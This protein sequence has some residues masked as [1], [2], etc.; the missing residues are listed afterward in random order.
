LQ[1]LQKEIETE[2]EK[3]EDLYKKFQCYCTGNNENLNKAGEEAAAQIETLSAKVKQETAEKKQVEAELKQHKKDKADA[4]ADLDQATKIRQKEHAEYVANAGDTKQNIESTIS[5]IDALEKGGSAFLQTPMVGKLQALV[6]TGAFLD[7][8]DR[9]QVDA[10][11]QQS[12]DYVPQGGQ[13]V[14]I[15]KNMKD[16]MDKSLGGIVSE[17]ESDA[18][19]FA[20]LKAAKTKEIK[21]ATE[22][23][24]AKTQRKGELAVS[25]VQNENAAEDAT[26]ELSDAQKFLANLK[27][28]CADKAADYEERTKTRHQE[29]VAIG[30]AISV[31][32]DDDALDV[33]KKS[34]PSPEPAPQ[35][36][37]ASFL[38][39]GSKKANVSQKVK[40]LVSNL[41]ARKQSSAI[42]LLAHTVSIKLATGV[43]FTKVL[44]MVDDMV[45]LLIQEGKDDEKHKNFCD[46]EFDSSDDENKAV[47]RKLASLAS[48]ISEINDEIAAL[49]D[50]IAVH[51]KEI[52]DLD[53]S[54][55]EA[56][57]QREEEHKEYTTKVQLNEAAI[58]LIH[59]AK[60][61]MNKFYNPSQYV[62]PK[63]RELTAEDRAIIAAGGEV[64]RS[65]P[66]QVIAGTQ[67]TVFVQLHTQENDKDAPAPPPETY[68]EYKK[69][70]EKSNGV[71]ALMDKLAR[72]LE[73]E[74]QEAEHFEKTAQRDYQEL[75]ADAQ[76][77]RA[78][79]SKS[80][81]DK[82]GSVANLESKVQ[83]A[84]NQHIISTD[85]LDQVKN[86]IL[87]LHQSC[88]FIIAN[89]E[90]RRESR[91]NEI[92]S[93]K[94]AKAVLSGAGYSF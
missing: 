26:R 73:K 87:D 65:L 17:E 61:K 57:E 32:N 34:L 33:F 37:R 22:A 72:D 92:E 46:K 94:N 16:E 6:S 27:Q 47:Q 7:S 51:Q 50:Q 49:K 41:N 88:D 20:G 8:N 83:E 90:V 2:G 42:A 58:Q 43:D 85:N 91:G 59:K 84:K 19:N 53:K 77:S 21:A 56:G 23:V 86:Y 74:S 38:E 60:N 66:P 79:N 63:Q 48:S 12:G 10:F 3:E 5:A 52:A 81:T 54:V 64:D 89:F 76:E 70:G 29:V 18:K 15:L 28:T 78:Q 93:L 35:A 39:K 4:Q 75:A 25:I 68:G 67:Q 55:A 71:I 45:T 11:L 14:G 44:K 1:D 80:V 69:K 82:Q 24:Q 31:L 9:E 13:I 30:E 36:V 40:A 62:A